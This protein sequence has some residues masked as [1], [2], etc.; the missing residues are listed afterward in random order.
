VTSAAAFL[1]R[2]D[3]LAD[4]VERQKYTRYFPPRDG[5]RAGTDRFLG[6]RMGQVFA[7]AAESD[8]MPLEEVERLL[9]SDIHE[10]RAGAMRIMSRQAKAKG[11]TA[12]QRRALFELYLRRHDRIDDWDLVDLAA[13]DVVGGWLV[14]R[15]RDVLDQLA[16]SPHPFE[17]RTAILAT[18][19]FIRRGELDDT[20]RIAEALVGDPHDLVQKGVGWALRTAGDVDRERLTA[21]LELHGPQMSRVALRYAI[22]HY[23]PAE[24]K[25]FLARRASPGSRQT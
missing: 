24:R 16:T 22:E 10:A 15:P 23:E 11:V 8:T 12:D 3:A 1:E 2:L 9:E 20:F 7:L 5:D 25:A 13:W 19:A 17:R 21:F 4:P 18:M 14:D 6:V